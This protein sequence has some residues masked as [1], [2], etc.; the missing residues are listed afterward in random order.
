M[1]R[2]KTY[3]IPHRR[4]REGKTDYRL[5][6]KL[7]KS[8]KPRFV[9]R[10]SSNNMTCQIIDYETMGDKVLVSSDSKILGKFG[11]K[12][13]CGNLPSAY[14]TG[15]LCALKARKDGI[16]EAILD[17]GLYSS[18]PGNRLYSA[19]KG[20]L[21]GG[22][23]IPCSEEIFPKPERIRGEHIAKYAQLLKKENPSKYK[24]I[25]S[26]YIKS[27][28]NPED[29]PKIFEQVKKNI[30]SSGRKIRKEKPEKTEKPVKKKKLRSL[31]KRSQ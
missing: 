22:L 6:L 15:L 8:G 21:N 12:F 13:H 26:R 5:R 16:N 4:K 18:S 14:L 7:L 30:I 31:Q 25:F 20:A 27:K 2:K 9:V 3:R 24:K 19:L 17:I 10:R 29:I 11:W 1:R 28:I 23:K